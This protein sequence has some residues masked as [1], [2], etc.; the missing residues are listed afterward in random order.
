M[1]TPGL[2]KM[3]HIFTVFMGMLQILPLILENSLFPCFI[4]IAD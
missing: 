2:A 4:A 1:G 3:L